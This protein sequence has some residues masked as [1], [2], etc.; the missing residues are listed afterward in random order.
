MIIGSGVAGLAAAEAIRQ[1][2]ASGQIWLLGDDPHGYYSRPGLAYFLSGEVPESMLF[3]IPDQEYKRLGI[4]WKHVQVNRIDTGGHRV[5]LQNGQFLPFDRLLL[6]TGSRAAKFSTPGVELHGVVKLDNLQ[7]AREIL[8]LV[9]KARAAVIVGGGVTAL[10]IVEGLHQRGLQNVHYLMRGDRYWNNVLDEDESRLIEQRLCDD[11][12]QIHHQTEIA[13]ILGKNGKVVGAI[14]RDGKSI[15]CEL[16]AYA[17]GVQPRVDLAIPAGVSVDR[18]ILVNQTLET[19]LA[20]IFAAGDVAQIF[21]PYSGK[22]MLDSLWG[23]AREQGW[24]AGLNMAGIQTLYRKSVPFNVTRLAGLTTSIIGTVGR[25]RDENMIAISHGDSETW[26]ELP[27]ITVTYSNF[28]VNHLRLMIGER[29]LIGAIVMGD[30]TLSQSIRELVAYEVD[31][32]PIRQQLIGKERP[33]GELLL[34]LHQNWKRTKQP[35]EPVTQPN[36]IH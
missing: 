27:D 19:N 1:N 34:E 22:A 12:I 29:A 25:G 6:A 24:A 35:K 2:D 23:P 36:R 9:R 4:F 32:S 14:T 11:K 28:D 13:E 33:S 17:I 3:P 10:E 15:P 8:Q 31:I 18:G 20:D 30:Q 7:D 21:D 5:E 26:R 16:V